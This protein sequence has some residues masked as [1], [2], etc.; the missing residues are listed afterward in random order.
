MTVITKTTEIIGR[1]G[2]QIKRKPFPVA[3]TIILIMFGGQADN[4]AVGMQVEDLEIVLDSHVTDQKKFAEIPFSQRW[5]KREQNEKDT[6]GNNAFRVANCRSDSNYG[7]GRYWRSYFS[8]TT[9]R[10]RGTS[11]GDSG[12]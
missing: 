4:P 6:F 12:P 7:T 11:G 9:H 10:I 5:E 1:E 8:A 2:L 3:Q